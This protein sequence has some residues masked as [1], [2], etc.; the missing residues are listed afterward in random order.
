MEVIV[1]ATFLRNST[2]S[3]DRDLQ[4]L[5]SQG[6]IGESIEDLT[7]IRDAFALRYLQIKNAAWAIS[8]KPE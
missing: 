1:Y 8:Y 3:I 4:A 6:V 7:Q 2:A 5:N